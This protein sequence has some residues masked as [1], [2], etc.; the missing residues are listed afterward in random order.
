MNEEN[1][2]DSICWDND[3]ASFEGS[4]FGLWKPFFSDEYEVIGNIYENPELIE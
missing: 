2:I 4:K 1:Y 3:N